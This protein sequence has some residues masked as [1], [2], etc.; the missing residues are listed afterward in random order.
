MAQTPTPP[1]AVPIRSIFA[2]VPTETPTSA[3]GVS[4]T[5]LKFFQG[6]E[7]AVLSQI[8][9]IVGLTITTVT[10][11]TLPPSLPASSAGMIYFVSDFNH[12]LQWDGT[13]WIWAPGENGSG[14]I[15]SFLISPTGAGWHLCDGSIVHRLNS[16]GSVSNVTLP[17]YAIAAYLKL[18][19][20]A[21]AG[22]NAPSGATQSISGGTPAGTISGSSDTTSAESASQAVQSGAGVT[23]AAHPHTHTVTPTATFAGAAL[24][25]H[26]HGP[27]TIDLENTRLLAY[28]RQ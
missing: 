14:Y 28:Y 3:S 6:F 4:W 13:K 23:V 22:P 20:S 24:A 17:N 21:A 19:T 12:L 18:G 27:G 16:D 2:A 8:A 5:W 10:Q 26:S 25:S 7:Q 15:S 11:A 9:A 1:P